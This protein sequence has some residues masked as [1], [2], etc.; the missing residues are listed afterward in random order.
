VAAGLHTCWHAR[1]FAEK[2]ESGQPGPF[3]RQL[4]RPGIRRHRTGSGPTDRDASPPDNRDL[5]LHA[6]LEPLQARDHSTPP[7]GI[8]VDDQFVRARSRDS[9]EGIDATL[10]FQQQRIRTLAWLEGR[11]VLT[12]LPLQVPDSVD[13]AQPD[14]VALDRGDRRRL[15]QPSVSLFQVEDS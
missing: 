5:E 15:S 11:H 3:H 13:P 1:L 7:T 8:R 4:E 12:A 6:E 10:R 9:D 14:H 2:V